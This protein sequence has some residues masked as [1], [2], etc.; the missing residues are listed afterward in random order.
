MYDTIDT[1]EEI[2]T[3]LEYVGKQSSHTPRKLFTEIGWYHQAR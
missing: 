3:G 1:G 2:L